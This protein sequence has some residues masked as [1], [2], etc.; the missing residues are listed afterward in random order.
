MTF[1]ERETAEE[2]KKID[3]LFPLLFE[4]GTLHFHI[5][6]GATNYIVGPAYTF[7]FNNYNK[8]CS[9]LNENY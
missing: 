3:S 1:Q 7:S 5:A 2:I 4:Q 6:V 9:A 8:D